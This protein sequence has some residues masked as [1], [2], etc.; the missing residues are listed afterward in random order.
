MINNSTYYQGTYL[1]DSQTYPEIAQIEN[2]DITT[3][4]CI[5]QLKEWEVDVMFKLLE[6]LEKVFAEEK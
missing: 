6:A 4:K 3:L 2:T 5:R 1:L